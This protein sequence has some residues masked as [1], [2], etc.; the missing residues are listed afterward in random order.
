MANI[1]GDSFAF[2]Q[3]NILGTA[4]ADSIYGFLENDT[5]NGAGG[6]DLIYGGDGVDTLIGGAGNDSL[7]GGDGEDTLFGDDGN[8]NLYGNADDD[9]LSGGAGN[10]FL[11][12]GGGDDRLFGSTG[13]DSLFGGNGNDLLD[14]GSGNDIMGGGDGNDIYYVDSIFDSIFEYDL[15][16]GGTDRVN[17]SIDFTLSDNFE[18]LLLTGITA[19]NGTGNRFANRLQ[20]NSADNILDGKAG[21]DTLVSSLGNDTLIGGSGNDTYIVSHS[22]NTIEEISTLAYEIDTVAANIDFT[23]G[24]NL[25]SLILEGINP[26]NGSG[27]GLAN[28]LIGNSADNLLQG[29]GGN[30]TLDGEAGNDTLNGGS[31]NDVLFGG[32]GNDTM[33]GG[34]GNDI[35]YVDGIGDITTETSTS[36]TEIDTVVSTVSRTLGANLERLILR[37]T[38]ALS[39]VGN[40]LNN[41]LIGNA[42]DNILVGGAGN[43]SLRGEAG[44]D[45]LDGGSGIDYASYSTAASGVSVSLAIAVAQNTLGAGNDTLA[46]FENLLGS[47]SNDTLLGNSGNN[48]IKGGSGNDFIYGSR[49]NDILTGELGSD[50]FHFANTLSVSNSDSITDFNA[51]ADTMRLDRTIFTNLTTLGVLG[52]QFFRASATGVAGD[53]NDFILYNTST[54]AIRY[55]S[56]GSGGGVAVQFARLTTKPTITAADFFVVA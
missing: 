3:D 14:G 53:A 46:N 42:G 18:Q 49:G 51:A 34:E 8:D 21:D 55:D 30:D 35:F 50:T 22:T 24:D 13:T 27:N 38:A 37:G 7:V 1:F 5:L 28:S 56:D 25:E 47:S 11:S 26:L 39:G 19:I 23:L 52:A 4:N 2:K 31:G 54:G 32:T 33:I 20:G 12:G 40:S 44:D 10:D 43:D 41:T 15:L 9:F 29:F 36:A 45:D 17:S 16:S 6:D 48:R